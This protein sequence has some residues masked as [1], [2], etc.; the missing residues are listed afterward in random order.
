MTAWENVAGGFGDDLDDIEFVGRGSSGSVYRATQRSLG[1][2]VAI[3]V[4]RRFADDETDRVLAEARA[5]AALS[6]HANVASLYGQGV[7]DDG[8]PYLVME[9]APCGSLEDRVREQGPLP[10][11]LWRRVGAELASALASAHDAGV[12]HCDV[13]PSN[14]LFAADGSVRLADFG[15]ARATGMT[16]GTLDSI[17]G[18][19]AYVPP[20]LLDGQQPC[21]ANDVYSLALTIGFARSGESPFGSDLTLAQAV[22]A[23]QSGVPAN[24]DPE[25]PCSDPSVDAL[26]SSATSRNP[27]QR[28]SARDLSEAL[29]STGGTNRNGQIVEVVRSRPT[30][31][32]LAAAMVA[33]IALIGLLAVRSPG[34]PDEVGANPEPEFHLC[35]EYRVFVR[36]RE[37]LLTNVSRELEQ[38]ASPT[39]VVRR[40]LHDY[41]HDFA[42][43]VQPF[44]QNVID[45]GAVS[46]EVTADQLADV[47]VAENLR[48]LNGGKVFLF[49]GEGG[50][51]D[52]AGLPVFL[53]EP[54]RIFSAVNEYAITECPD[55]HVDVSPRKARLSAAIHFNLLNPEFMESFYSDPESY[56]VI[57]AREALLIATYSWGFFEGILA[58]HADW[59]FEMLDRH[60]EVR[61][62]LSID[63]PEVLLRAV[64]LD[65]TLMDMLTQPDWLAEVQYGIDQMTPAARTG[66][67][68]VYGPQ[69][70]AL[71]LD[72]G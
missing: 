9:Y 60:S 45:A 10:E 17:E 66:I 32:V 48:V 65:P 51:F 6:W 22:A 26:L 72:L 21:P 35:D 71:G 19:L 31:P 69:I 41:P 28:P 24:N 59:L 58:G 12:T 3:K 30:W 14:V 44:I 15:I 57:D 56:D 36:D 25:A 67:S 20:E 64:V 2:V 29:A 61:R 18:S 68:E 13:K 42:T 27:G 52:P 43:I 37:Q 4:F 62:V 16:S 5:Q 63:R 33:A 50:S 54:A 40:L 38:S 49:D 8:F 46:G 53:Y 55:V 7:T 23:I 39:D 70:K 34:A 11:V 1:R 47:V